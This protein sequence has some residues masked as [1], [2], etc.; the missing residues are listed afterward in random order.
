MNQAHP[1][2]S[3]PSQGGQ[4]MFMGCLVPVSA[5]RVHG[6]RRGW[7]SSRPGWVLRR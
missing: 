1:E 2:P 4:Q 5:G 3:M 7:H 6:L